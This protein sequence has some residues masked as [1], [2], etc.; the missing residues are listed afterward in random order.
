MNRWFVKRKMRRLL[1]QNLRENPIYREI[2]NAGQFAAQ[3]ADITEGP[4]SSG[5]LSQH[6]LLSEER[7]NAAWER[8]EKAG[9][10]AKQ[11]DQIYHWGM[12]FYEGERLEKKNKGKEM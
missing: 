11:I 1:R 9:L 4:V 10:T 2:F 7:F 5:L 12:N 8:G 6:Q 3:T